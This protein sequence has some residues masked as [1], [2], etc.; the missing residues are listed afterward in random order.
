MVEVT[1]LNGQK[2]VINGDQIERIEARP[3][4]ILSLSSGRKLLVRES[5]RDIVNLLTDYRRSLLQG[6]MPWTLE[7]SESHHSETV[8]EAV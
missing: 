8:P 6:A 5:V 2:M 4:T 7:P 1:K 3:D